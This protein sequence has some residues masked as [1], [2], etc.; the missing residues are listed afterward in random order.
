MRMKW[1]GKTLLLG[2]TLIRI[3]PIEEILEEL[4]KTGTKK[5]LENS[6]V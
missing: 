1:I 3:K 4:K 6:L 2:W 5:E